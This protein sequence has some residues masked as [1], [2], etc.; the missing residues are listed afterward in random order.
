VGIFFG[1]IAA[2]GAAAQL[3]DCWRK[4]FRVVSAG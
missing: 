4:H 3:Y 2:L 1:V